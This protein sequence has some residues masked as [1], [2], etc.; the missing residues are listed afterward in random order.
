[1]ASLDGKV[2]TLAEGLGGTDLGRPYTGG[3]FSVARNGRVGFT[4]NTP[5]RPADV[6]AASHGW[7]RAC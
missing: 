5:E 1:M 6:A 7:R 3:A 4:H 2:R